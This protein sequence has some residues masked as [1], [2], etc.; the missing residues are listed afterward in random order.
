MK[1]RVF[2]GFLFITTLMFAQESVN[3]YKYIVVPKKFDFLKEENQ[4]RVNTFTKYQFEKAGFNAIYDDEKVADLQAN[5]CL[6]LKAN[7]VDDS[8]L[9]TTKMK[10]TLKNCQGDVVFTSEEGKSKIKDYEGAYQEALESAFVSIK[11]L[12]YEYDSSEALQAKVPTQPTKQPAPA[13]LNQNQ[14]TVVVSSGVVEAADE[15]V[16]EASEVSQAAV[17]PSPAVAETP[18]KVESKGVLLYAQPIA[19]GFQLIDS[20]PKVVYKITKTTQPNY[21]IIQ[22]MNGFVYKKDGQW[23]AEYYEG[24]VLKQE[25]LNIKF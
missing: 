4:Y 19:N 15:V 24:D 11:A 3:N 25:A 20:T 13:P 2:L 14:S 6:G 7:V 5:P 18:N 17:N 23:I 10:V 22:G 12:N 16:E 21:F 1:K 9:F 8:G